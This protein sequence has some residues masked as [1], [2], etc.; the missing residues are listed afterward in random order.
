MDHWSFTI[1]I[2]LGLQFWVIVF[3]CF[4]WF[5]FWCI[6]FFTYAYLSKL[7]E[8]KVQLFE[9]YLVGNASRF[10]LSISEDEK[11]EQAVENLMVKGLN[12]WISN[13]ETPKYI[14]TFV[15]NIPRLHEKAN[16]LGQVTPFLI[17]YLGEG[18]LDQFLYM[19]SSFLYTETTFFDG[20]ALCIAMQM[21]GGEMT[22]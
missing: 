9:N 2:D 3:L 20:I 13:P 15:E 12:Q 11:L 4:I 10:V 1:E 17:Y 21:V 8:K 7:L 18:L 5:W 6:S 19:F 22:S 14:E 16:E